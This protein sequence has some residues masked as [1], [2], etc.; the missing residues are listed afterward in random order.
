[1]ARELR[2]GYWMA[3]VVTLEV[4]VFA[5]ELVWYLVAPSDELNNVSYIACL[6]LAPS[7]VTMIACTPLV[8]PEG[9]RSFTRA[10]L[11]LAAMYGVLCA[12]VYYLQLSVLRLGTFPASTDALSSIWS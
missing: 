7:Y 8:S 3:I 5:V 11:G 10:A 1:M 12:G 2:L 6:L 9:T 4:A